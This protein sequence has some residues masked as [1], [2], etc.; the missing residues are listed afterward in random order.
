MPSFN[1]YYREAFFIINITSLCI[2]ALSPV[3]II[4]TIKILSSL[5]IIKYQGRAVNLKDEV[6]DRSIG[7]AQYFYGSNT[8]SHEKG[9]I[10]ISNKYYERNYNSL[11]ILIYYNCIITVTM[12]LTAVR[13]LIS[14]EITFLCDPNLQ[15][16]PA[17]DTQFSN[18]ITDCS[19]YA[20]ELVQCH[21]LVISPSSAI[22]FCGG[23]LQIGP[24]LTFRLSTW[25]LLRFTNKGK[26]VKIPLTVLSFALLYVATGLSST[27]LIG[28]SLDYYII[29]IIDEQSLIEIISL[30]AIIIILFSCPWHLL[31]EVKMEEENEQKQ[32]PS[33]EIQS[34]D[35]V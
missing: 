14:E 12:L 10:K 15:C 3:I 27:V 30:V 35:I 26:R 32:E 22:A 9:Y 23:L 16:F 31:Q 7:L 2:Y 1:G 11:H 8:V 19:E 25:L 24:P 5:P 6:F 34:D 17:N 20:N 28:R 13:F 18:R 33:N 4:I 29:R 21:S